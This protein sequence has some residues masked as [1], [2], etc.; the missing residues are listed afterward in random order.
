MKREAVEQRSRPK[1]PRPL[2]ARHPCSISTLAT[3]TSRCT[4]R[5]VSALALSSPCYSI[6]GALM[7]C[8]RHF[9]RGKGVSIYR[10]GPAMHDPAWGV[11]P[12]RTSSPLRSSCSIEK[13]ILTSF[14]QVN[15]LSQLVR[16]VSASTSGRARIVR[17]GCQ[18]HPRTCV[19]V[20]EIE[21]QR[22]V[23]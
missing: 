1:Q 20:V 19:V 16:P 10:P 23:E 21:A 18:W 22:R 4:H 17:S 11:L 8:S 3:G 7:A 6:S 9:D 12:T 15:P 14:V 13:V 5:Q 2:I